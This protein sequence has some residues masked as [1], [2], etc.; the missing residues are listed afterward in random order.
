RDAP[1]GPSAAGGKAGEY[2]NGSMPAIG[3]GYLHASQWDGIRRVF[4]FH[5]VVVLQ[6]VPGVRVLAGS[7]HQGRTHVREESLPIE[8]NQI[9]R[10]QRVVQ[11]EGVLLV[12]REPQRR[13]LVELEW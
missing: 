12:S 8:P 7:Y 9:Q 6:Q 3:L 10:F 1:D 5:P 13:Q 4:V 11:R 2:P